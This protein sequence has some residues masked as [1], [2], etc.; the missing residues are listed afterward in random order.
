[1]IMK[2]ETKFLPKSQV[3]LTIEESA[4]NLA[5]ARV[6]VLQD[7]QKNANVKWFRKG[8][9]IPEAILVKQFG[10]QGIL[11][12]TVERAIDGIYKESLRSEKLLPVAAAEI[13]EIVSQNPLIVK[14]VVEV[15]PKVQ[16]KEGYKSLKLPK[17]SL[18]VS[19]SEVEAALKDIQTRFTHFHDVGADHAAHMGDRITIDTDGYD[20]DGTF[21]ES[22]SMRE[23]PLVLGSNLLVPGFEEQLVGM[24]VGEEREIDVTFPSD[25]HNAQFAGKKTKFKVKMHK[26]EHAH[27]PEFTQEFMKELR[28]KDLD[29]NGFKELVRE[30]LLDT[31][32]SNDQIERE[33][34]LIEALLEY[35]EL[36]IGDALLAEQTN[37]V[38]QEIKEN[39]ARDGLK[40]S[41]Y[42]ASLW[43]S[44]E[45]YKER[46]VQATALKRIQGELILNHLVEK[47]NIEVTD[48]ELT[49]EIEKIMARFGSP[50]VLD[51]LKTLYVPGSKYYEEL[52]R[53]HAFR[54]VIDSFF[55]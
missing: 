50:D 15:F 11:Q 2:V 49:P 42:L 37:M 31:K 28:W 34:K 27:A 18:S 19:D 8:A 40:V 13:R 16:V 32:K 52:R 44:E 7:L 53:R 23:Y 33:L 9:H 48:A 1:M 17:T 5:K 36:D 39:I 46:H 51:R 4:E 25:Y 54:K 3:E 20:L 30:E 29:F 21:L 6:E 43:L 47:E 14:I 41:D 24:K 55:A 22:T 10:E 38:F 12:M 45:A 35:T 26:A